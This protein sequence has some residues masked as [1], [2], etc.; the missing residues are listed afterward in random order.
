MDIVKWI[1]PE[2]N[3]MKF[4]LGMIAGFFLALWAWGYM[5]GVREKFVQLDAKLIAVEAH[6]ETIETQLRTIE[7]LKAQMNTFDK[8]QA[9]L[10]AIRRA[11]AVQ[12]V[13]P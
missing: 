4:L 10:V 3:A 12:M 2:A 13:E 6:L 5:S 9:E 8:I 11:L 7:Q 1:F